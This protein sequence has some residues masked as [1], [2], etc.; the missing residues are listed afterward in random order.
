MNIQRPIDFSLKNLYRLYDERSGGFYNSIDKNNQINRAKL[1]RY[2]ARIIDLLNINDFHVL[3]NSTVN[4][5][6]SEPLNYKKRVDF[7]S[8]ERGQV[9]FG[10]VGLFITVL[11]KLGGYEETIDKLLQH[12]KNQPMDSLKAQEPVLLLWLLTA[13]NNES[14]EQYVFEEKKLEC[15]FLFL[16]Y[17]NFPT[18]VHAIH[19]LISNGNI[20]EA[21]N[22]YT[23]LFDK[24]LL[25]NGEW[26]LSY[27][28][29]LRWTYRKAF[30]VHQLGMG[31]FYL[32]ELYEA[33][34]DFSILD[35]VRKNIEFGMNFVGENRIYRTFRNKETRSY[36]CAY[37]YVGLL[38]AEE[39]GIV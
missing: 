20:E 33:C 22:W 38:K 10:D 24:F 5:L 21:H 17:V 25:K 26:G 2:N 29:S 16:N 14:L 15:K 27:F 13:C 7:R 37:D 30:S 32:L 12:L 6:K 28:P 1:L 9:T 35:V 18:I 23:F 4:Y 39:F 31:P 34:G 3:L 36:E 11:K 19:Y 8:K